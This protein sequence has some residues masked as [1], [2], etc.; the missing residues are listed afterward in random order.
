VIRINFEKCDVALRSQRLVKLAQKHVGE[1]TAKVYEALLC[2]LDERVPRVRDDLM[3]YECLEDEILDTPTATLYE[4][5]HRL[6]AACDIS[7]GFESIMEDESYGNGASDVD[8]DVTAEESDD[9]SKRRLLVSHHLHFLSAD[10]RKFVQK[11]SPQR[12][13]QWTVDFRSLT[14]SL[15]DD[16]IT[17]TIN[18]KFGDLAAKVVR[19]LKGRGKLDEKQVASMAM[20]KSKEIR[21]TLTIMQGAGFVDTQEV[22]RDNSRQPSRT[23]YLWFFDQDRCRLMLIGQCYQAIARILQRI[24]AEKGS[25]QS[26]IDKAERTDVVGREDEYLSTVEKSVLK[27]WHDIEE[28]LQVQVSRIDETIGVLRDYVMPDLIV[29]APGE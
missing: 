19:M 13:G 11:I 18:A 15:L 12:G 1:P 8:S 2:V 23:L 4:V 6:D 25:V 10:S 16:E 7:T 14:A 5:T 3:E 9:A 29:I 27:E 26:V 17:T 28:K 21:G 24:K 22:P 20:L